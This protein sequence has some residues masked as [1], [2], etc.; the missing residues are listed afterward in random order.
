MSKAFGKPHWSNTLVGKA[1]LPAH[2][3]MPGKSAAQ[4]ALSNRWKR[5]KWN[6]DLKTVYKGNII[7]V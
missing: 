2:N 1:P 6:A 7:Y 4:K 3:R 5:R